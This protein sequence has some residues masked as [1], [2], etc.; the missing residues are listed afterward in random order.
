MP[1]LTYAN[2]IIYALLGAGKITREQMGKCRAISYEDED[3]NEIFEF[4][5]NLERYT[6]LIYHEDD[7]LFEVD[8][9]PINI[10][11]NEI[12]KQNKRFERY[13]E[14][15]DE[16]RIAINHKYVNPIRCLINGEEY[17]IIITDESEQLQYLR[18]NEYTRR[19][20]NNEE[21]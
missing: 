19:L 7:T 14:V 9:Y 2:Q 4:K 6:F 17:M 8:M 16:S 13:G 5:L 12:E 15:R 18:S 3:G 21:L 11:R 10:F 20:L 1:E